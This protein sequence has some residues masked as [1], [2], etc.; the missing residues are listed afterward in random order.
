MLVACLWSRWADPA[1]VEPDLYSFAAVTDDPEPEFAAAGNDRAIVNLK[2]E[3]VE[4]WLTPKWR[5]NEELMALLDEK[6]HLFYDAV[7]IAAEPPGGR[8]W[9]HRQAS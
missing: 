2:P 7:Q 6:R 9:S 8:Y 1:D 4:A 5:S 3:S